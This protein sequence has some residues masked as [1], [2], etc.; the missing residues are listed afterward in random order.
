MAHDAIR[1]ITRR[2]GE[3]EVAALGASHAVF[4]L[5][6]EETGGRYSVTEFTLAPPPT[7]G[8]PLHRHMDADEAMYVLEGTVACTVEEHTVTLPAG[9]FALVPRGVSHTVANPGPD[10]VRLLIV[11][12]PGGY[13]GYWREM[14]QLLAA[15]EGPPDPAR[16][17]AL[18]VQY[19]LETGGQVRRFALD[20]E[21]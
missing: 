21:G 16:V 18:Q 9:S 2:P 8:P 20:G 12:V 6:G 1:P 17:L 3:A 11:L 13:E 15:G 7:P 4:L 5:P 14:G 19:H 10:H